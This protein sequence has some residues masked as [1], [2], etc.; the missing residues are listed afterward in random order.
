MPQLPKVCA[1]NNS[2]INLCHCLAVDVYFKVRGHQQPG[3]THTVQ[4]PWTVCQELKKP[5]PAHPRNSQ[6]G[7][8]PS[9]PGRICLA[10]QV[11]W[12]APWRTWQHTSVNRE[13]LTCLL[14]KT[15]CNWSFISPPEKV[16]HVVMNVIQE[17]RKTNLD[18]KTHWGGSFPSLEIVS[19]ESSSFLFVYTV[20]VPHLPAPIASMTPVKFSLLWSHN[21]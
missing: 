1:C 3:A 7:S 17:G 21:S 10:F 4:R 16:R 8:V 15:G 18:H 14:T 11:Y 19:K 13:T 9:S 12:E 20:V 5:D 2:G 6:K